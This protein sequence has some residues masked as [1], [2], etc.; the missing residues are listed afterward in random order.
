MSKPFDME[1][2]LLLANV[3]QHD[4]ISCDVCVCVYCAGGSLGSDMAFSSG[5]LHVVSIAVVDDTRCSVAADFSVV[6]EA[7]VCAGAQNCSRQNWTL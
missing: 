2:F 1:L 7:G 4:R 6:R 3:V 5:P